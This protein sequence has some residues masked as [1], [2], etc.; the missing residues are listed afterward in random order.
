MRWLWIGFAALTPAACGGSDDHAQAVPRGSNGGFSSVSSGGSTAGAAGKAGA[1]GGAGTGGTSNTGAVG[2][3]DEGGES[4]AG[5]EGSLA[6]LVEIVS[7]VEVLDPNA[8]A[9]LP[10]TNADTERVLVTCS[11]SPSTANG[12]A[13]VDASSVK[14]WVQD[15]N[16]NK[17][18]AVGGKAAGGSLYEA[19]VS[20]K[21][22][23]S[24]NVTFVCSA[25]DRSRVPIEGRAQISQFVDRGPSITPI[26]PI[27]PQGLRTKTTFDFTVAPVPLWS[28]PDAGAAVAS[29]SLEV[30]GKPITSLVA[31]PKQANHYIAEIDFNDRKLFPDTPTGDI[32]VT[33]TASNKRKPTAVVNDLSYTFLL[34]GTGPTT[35][36]TRPVPETVIGGPKSTIVEF[37]VEDEESGV[38]VNSVFLRL[39]N[40]PN[41]IAYDSNDPRWGL[42]IPPTKNDPYI[43]TFALDN[44]QFVDIAQ[45]QVT[46]NAS[47]SDVAGNPGTASALALRLDN[48][49]PLIS[50]DPPKARIISHGNDGRDTYCS[51]PF[52][53]VGDA[54]ANDT[55]PVQLLA[56]FRAFIWERTNGT[57]SADVYW[58]A[59]IDP[60]TPHLYLQPDPTKAIII[61][62][63]GDGV[64]DDIAPDVKKLT[65][66]DL[67]A[68]AP[69]GAGDTNPNDLTLAP[70]ATDPRYRLT[71]KTQFVD[72]KKL[73]L[74]NS[75]D[76]QF[77]AGQHL[78]TIGVANQAAVWAPT[79]LGDQTY[80]CTGS[81]F[82]LS[83]LVQRV[84]NKPVEGWICLAAEVSDRQGNHAV[85][86]PLRVCF[87][88]ESTPE[89]PSCALSSSIPPSC[90]ASCTPP[91][92]DV[93]G[94][95]QAPFLIRY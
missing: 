55:G 11:A 39:N 86:K 53:P 44:T 78:P 1:G 31:D 27:T 52:D 77:V 72:L 70:D 38:D 74:D 80:A 16:D 64:C 37:T 67:Q 43:F 48:Q 62:T 26:K 30:K 25:Y 33:I 9:V 87:D 66:F 42:R 85:S 10:V 13:P 65:S 75:S 73:C 29:V 58:Y 46:L 95:D 59:G 83:G 57:S 34:D 91:A 79:V 51:A 40:D 20:L 22:V 32:P 21:D 71:C 28:K 19:I 93:E 35:K 24:G 8:G 5:G 54:A 2:G 92:F 3:A 6:P 60:Q 90:T 84:N 12:A 49:S 14:V 81:Q 36:I 41:P 88:S 7:P 23:P 76:M 18:P 47:G 82:E 89:A 69:R 63:N 94:A 45:V 4:G 50:L 68:V 56:R 17:Y 61:D 15:G